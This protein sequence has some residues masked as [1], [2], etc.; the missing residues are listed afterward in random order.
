MS[1]T[2]AAIATG[3]AISA[4][5]IIRISGPKAIPAADKLFRPKSGVRLTEAVP[6]RMYYGTLTGTGGEVIDACMCWISRAPESYTGEDTAEFHCHGSP[7]VLAE[8]LR[9]LFSHGVR[10]AEP[11]AFTKRAFLNSRMDLT[12]AEAV[13]D[14]IEAESPVAVQNAAGQLLGATSVRFDAI[15]NQ[16]IDI[17]AHF[18]AVIDY[19]DEDIEDFQLADY[20]ATLS[21]T[22]RELS[23]ML[24][25]HESG[26]NLISGIPTAIIG[27]PN[28]GKS[29]LLNTLLGY[30]RAIV[31]P[32]PGTTRDTVEEKI[33][34][35]GVLLRMI[36]TAGLRET[37]DA[38]EKLG[39]ERTLKAIADAKL[40]ILVLDGSAPLEEAD[41][42]AIRAIPADVAQIAV[43]NK[44]D[45]PGELSDT[46]L[47]ELG[48]DFCYVSALTGAGVDDLRKKVRAQFPDLAAPSQGGLITNV[49]QADAI[50]RARDGISR[51]IAAITDAITPDA[52]LTE[53]ESARAAI[54]E[55]T[56]KN[57]RA[58]AT[59]RIF[60]RFCVGK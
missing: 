14:L 15:Y 13:I 48:F 38:V 21:D 44:S 47:A 40:V 45:L 42:K 20:L 46:E 43:V 54:G 32:I 31:T 27:R 52:V 36:D 29:S 17:L 2:I 60:E 28:A 6:R 1:D 56:G 59:D 16:L 58:D 12:Q 49:R 53:I 34:L 25:T 41:Y 8:V 37:H 19:P 18:H 10:Q 5:G 9:A 3:G 35:G 23:R 4:I 26:L 33:L 39:I 50:L 30:E 55:L 22:A 51:A 11:G 24:Q 7:V 57:L